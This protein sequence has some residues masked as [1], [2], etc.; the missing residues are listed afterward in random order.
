LS[1]ISFEYFENKIKIKFK[2]FLLSKKEY[3]NFT[4]LKFKTFKT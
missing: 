1:I 4:L 2:S 3:I